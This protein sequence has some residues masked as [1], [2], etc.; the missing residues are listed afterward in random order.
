MYMWVLS[1]PR[2]VC[3]TVILV[4]DSPVKLMSTKA[5]EATP[6]WI[7]LQMRDRMQRDET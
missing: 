3:Q 6:Y 5:Y 1:Y 2:D 7:F 4:L